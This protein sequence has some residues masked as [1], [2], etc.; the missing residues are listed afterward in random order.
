MST[1]AEVFFG[2]VLAGY[3]C[4]LGP[5]DFVFFYVRSYLDQPSSLPIGFAF[6]L[7]TEPFRAAALFPFFEGLVS[8]GWLKEKQS[9]LQRIDENDAFSLLI[10]N[11]EDLIGAISVKETESEKIDEFLQNLS[12][13]N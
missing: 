10:H 9:A 1:A 2:D 7:R 12:R 4:K 5:K 3:L 11:G 6:P 8:E 13:R